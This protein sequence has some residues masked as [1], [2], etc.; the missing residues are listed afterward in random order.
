M[1][2]F[3]IGCLTIAVIWILTQWLSRARSKEFIEYLS[4]ALR[5]I[6]GGSY[7]TRLH[8]FN[9]RRWNPLFQ[10]V[11]HMAAAIEGEFA[12]LS[13]ERDVLQHILHGMTTG[14][15]YI[16]Q[17]GKV[18]MINESAEMMFRRPAEQW[19]GREHWVVF[20]QYNISA[21]IDN[22]LLFGTGWQDEIK[23]RDNLPLQLRLIAIPSA[24]RNLGDNQTAYDALLLCTDVSNWKRLERLRSEFVANVSHE[25]KT[26]ISAIRGFAETLLDGDVDTETQRTFLQTI[27]EESNRMALLVSD[28]LEL[29]KLEA[30]EKSIQPMPITLGPVLERAARRLQPLAERKGLELTVEKAPELTVWADEDKLLQV[31]LNLVA[32]AVHYTPAGGK[33]VVSCDARVDRVKIHVEDT[34]V[35]IHADHLERVFERFYRVHK[36]RSRASGGTG[37][38]LAIVKHIVTEHGGEVGVKSEVGHGSDFWFTLSRVTSDFSETKPRNE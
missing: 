36:D 25:L 27:F 23:I 16:N 3:L 35:G 32:N 20:R 14:V 19:V 34:G 28:L 38:G 30:A 7:H 11:N 8:D 5:G 22:V 4:T 10:S 21:A 1:Y 33:I 17:S 26:P 12:G 24:H 6:A 29:S 9:H 15:V 31:L 2:A 37:L 13:Q 18:Q